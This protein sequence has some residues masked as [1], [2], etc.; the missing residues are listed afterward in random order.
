M[1]DWHAV[2][3]FANWQPLHATHSRTSRQPVV[4]MQEFS[5]LP[6]C[7]GGFGWQPGGKGIAAASLHPM[8]RV[9][10]APVLPPVA[11]APETPPV[12]GDPETPPVDPGAPPV[13]TT[14]PE[15]CA[16]P[17]DGRA[18]PEEVSVPPLPAAEEPPEPDRAPPVG[19]PTEPP[20]PPTPAPPVELP[21]IPSDA[22]S[23]LSSA[24]STPVAQAATE[25]L[26]VAEIRTTMERIFVRYTN[27]SILAP[28]SGGR[29]APD[30]RGRTPAKCETTARAPRL[31]PARRHRGA[32]GRRERAPERAA[33]R[34]DRRHRR[35]PL[36]Q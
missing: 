25:R 34:A 7:A 27:S 9:P 28:N 6:H 20:V 19:A 1:T 29:K 26:T 14:P 8:G 5:T 22:S 23:E 3:L 12:P 4:D 31:A 17:V 2:Q 33:C 11:G 21:P 18:P 10:P 13:E 24:G 35:K 32:S 30:G 36:P 16:P 15:P